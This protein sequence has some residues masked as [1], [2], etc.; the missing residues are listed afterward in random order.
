M[1]PIRVLSIDGGGIRGVIPAR[2][3]ARL[4]T[5]TAR[6]TYELFDLIVGTS[7]GGIAAMGLVL[8]KERGRPDSAAEIG[9]FYE[10]HGPLIF[11]QATLT[12][13]RTREDLRELVAKVG[14]QAAMFGSNP[15]AGNARYS[16]VALEKA[17]GEQFG[18]A[19][20]SEAIRRVIVTAYDVTGGRPVLFDSEA[21]RT[22]GSADYL[23]RD[24]ARAT[25]AA[26]TVFPPKVLPAAGGSEHIFIDGGVFAN[27]PAMVGYAEAMAL[28]GWRGIRVKTI[29]L[30]SVGTGIPN[31]PSVTYEDFAGQSWVRLAE[32]MFQ[33]ANRGRSF[34]DDELLEHLLGGHYHRFEPIL[35]MDITLDDSSRAAVVALRHLADDFV[36]GIED[37]LSVLAGVLTD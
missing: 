30:V 25:S 3:L 15:E 8:P 11:P 29:H 24:V 20:L 5:L 9:A 18:E 14:M 34:L 16:P 6:P 13:P 1:K 23:M 31:P 7:I 36:A 2:V 17:L 21:A 28:A 37:E 19:R 22:N 4:E 27:N 26:P 12:F 10:R 32:D 35:P 33:A